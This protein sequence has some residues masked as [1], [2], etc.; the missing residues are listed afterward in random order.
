MAILYSNIGSKWAKMTLKWHPFAPQILIQKLRESGFYI[1][2]GGLRGGHIAKSTKV[3]SPSPLKRL[4]ISDS[5]ILD[6][7]GARDNSANLVNL[8]YKKWPLYDNGSKI[9]RVSPFLLK[10]PNF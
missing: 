2:L 5:C 10:P 4:K 8:A 1:I 7:K 6:S 3:L 9:Y